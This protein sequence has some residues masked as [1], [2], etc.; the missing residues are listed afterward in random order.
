[1]LAA[2]ALILCTVVLFKMKRERYA[3]VTIVPAAWL[4]VCTLTAGVQK[5]VQPDPAIGFLAHAARFADALAGGQGAGAGE[6]LAEMQRVVFNDYVDA[7]L[8]RCSPRSWCVMVVYGIIA[9]IKAL[10][11]PRSTA[12]RSARWRRAGDD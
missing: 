6:E 2:I 5:V 1:M 4:V 11:N 9:C 12:L 10:R 3:W 8:A 7:T